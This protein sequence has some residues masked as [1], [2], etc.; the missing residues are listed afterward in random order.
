MSAG[1]SSSPW[2]SSALGFGAGLLASH[3][4]QNYCKPLCNNSSST[5]SSSSSWSNSSGT[6]ENKLQIRVELPLPRRD[7]RNNPKLEIPSFVNKQNLEDV[8]EWDGLRVLMRVDYNVKIKK[9]AVVDATRITSTID[10]LKALLAK[11]GAKGG[12][13]CITLITHLGR[14][15]PG[16]PNFDP[17][18][19]TCQ[20]IIKVL[21]QYLPGVNIE[22]LPD[23]VGEIVE[24]ATNSAKPGT[25][26]LCE[27]LRFHPE[28]TGIR[29]VVK[30]DGK[31]EK[32][33]IPFNELVVFREKLSRLG[34]VF[35]F[36]AFGAAHRAHSSIIGINLAPRVAGLL[37]QKELDYFG[38]VLGQPARPF[39][40]IVGGAKVSDKI[41]VLENMLDKVDELI[42]GGGMAYTLKKVRDGISIGNSIFEE[43][44]AELVPRI[45]KKAAERGVRI[46]LPVDHII[47]DK[48]DAAARVGV[49][50]D[51]AGIPN[52]WMALDVG[53]KSRTIFSEVIGRAKTVLWNGPL[54][55][56]EMG[57]F[58]GGTLSAMWDLTLASRSGATCIIGGGDTGSASKVFFVGE[59]PVAEQVSHVSTGGGSSLVLMEGKMLP[60]VWALSN[61]GDYNKPP[62]PDEKNQPADQGDD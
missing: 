22:F 32:V 4:Y 40:A 8:K 36:E 29:L 42:I 7:T 48:F 39:V 12:V 43:K 23:C 27:N 31:I 16:T 56:F 52:G 61:K 11:K 50:D 20:P 35:V 38:K 45:Y 6:D 9:G 49:T 47:A 5:S 57:P 37:M 59:R 24:S 58:G 62:P 13:K 51:K 41:L 14:P 44:G 26:F 54:G 28:E 15:A 21:Q 3:V 30:D 17:K 2:V 19:F 10:T 18:E 25:V 55:V 60:A 1:G 53:P 33:K 34:D 46:H